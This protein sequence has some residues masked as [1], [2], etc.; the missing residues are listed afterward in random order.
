VFVVGGIM[1]DIGLWRF[2]ANGL[3]G[4]EERE[5]GVKQVHKVG[6]SDICEIFARAGTGCNRDAVPTQRVRAI[7]NR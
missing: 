4:S 7:R 5:N 3:S 2:A 6:F 1:A